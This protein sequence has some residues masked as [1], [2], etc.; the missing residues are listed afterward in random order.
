MDLFAGLA[1]RANAHDLC[2]Y[3]DGLNHL[4]PL[5]TGMTGCHS[6]HTRTH[7]HTQPSLTRVGDGTVGISRVFILL[8][9]LLSLGPSAHLRGSFGPLA[10]RIFVCC[11]LRLC[12]VIFCCFSPWPSLSVRFR[13]CRIWQ[14]PDPGQKGLKRNRWSAPGPF[15]LHPGSLLSRRA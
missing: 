8:F 2:Q 7:T 13:S 9:L 12:Y 1:A 5:T 3:Q 15:N 6:Q 11:F 10:L 14:T 4:H